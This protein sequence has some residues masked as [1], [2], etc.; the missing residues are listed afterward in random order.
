MKVNGEYLSVAAEAEAEFTEKR[1]RFIGRIK[2]VE[3]ESCAKEFVESVRAAHREANHHVYAFII[4]AASEIQRSND[5]GEPA[6]TAGRP[7]LEALKQAG[8]QNV[9]LVVTRYFGGTLLGA[10]GLARAYGRAAGLAIGLAKPVRCLPSLLI[11]LHFAY[12]MIGR[13]ESLLALSGAVIRDKSFA[14]DVCYLAVVPI[15]RLKKLEQGL[16]EAGNG[17]IRLQDMGERLYL[18]EEL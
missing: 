6:G 15:S 17:A 1:S 18:Q 12:D 11:S 5:D 2:P 13:A 14:G 3:S 4:G 9:A 10:G 8:L 16:A 7:V